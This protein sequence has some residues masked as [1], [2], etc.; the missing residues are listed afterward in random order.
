MKKPVGSELR[1]DSKPVHRFLRGDGLEPRYGETMCSFW[2]WRIIAQHLR[3]GEVNFQ[4]RAR[5]QNTSPK[6]VA[7]NRLKELLDAIH[8]AEP[9]RRS[10][11][12]CRRSSNRAVGCR[13]RASPTVRSGGG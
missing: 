11:R 13:S 7:R 6:D 8:R 10:G 1:T 3:G 5:F 2:Q 4:N 12:D 9:P